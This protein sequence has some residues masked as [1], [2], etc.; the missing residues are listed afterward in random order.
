[1]AKTCLNCKYE[2]EWSAISTGSF[3]RRSCNCKFSISEIAV[4]ACV[5]NLYKNKIIRYSDDSGIFYNCC[6]VWEEKDK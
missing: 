3:P 6:T 4:P 2:P 5:P 1:M